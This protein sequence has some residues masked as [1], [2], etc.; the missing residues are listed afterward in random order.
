MTMR[1]GTGRRPDSHSQAD[2]QLLRHAGE[3]GCMTHPGLRYFRVADRIER[4]RGKAVTI[5]GRQ[6][7]TPDSLRLF[8]VAGPRRGEIFADSR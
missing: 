4:D 2:R 7:T 6:L 8:G 3:R 5:A 1:S